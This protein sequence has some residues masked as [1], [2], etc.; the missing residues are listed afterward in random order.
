LVSER[1]PVFFIPVNNLEGD[2]A[3]AAQAIIGDAY[4]TPERANL[5]TS[6]STNW[7]HQRITLAMCESLGLHGLGFMEHEVRCISAEDLHPVTSAIRDLLDHLKHQGVPQV[8]RSIG[9]ELQALVLADLPTAIAEAT[10]G[11]EINDDAGDVPSYL[12]FLVSLESSARQAAEAGAS[13]L[14]YRPQP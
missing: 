5:T 10:P 11:N 2:D 6:L 12:D 13:L 3:D 7:W 1:I 4:E 8:D 9:P 14:W